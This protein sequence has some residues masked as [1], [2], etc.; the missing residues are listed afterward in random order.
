MPTADFSGKRETDLADG[1]NQSGTGAGWPGGREPI[2]NAPGIV[3]GLIAALIGIHL[4]S[5]LLGNDAYEWMML[6]FSFIPARYSPPADLTGYVFPGGQAADV[7]TFVTHI[8]LH[9]DWT[10]VIINCIWMLIF[11]SVVARRLGA[12][13]FLAFSAVTAAIGAASN[14]AA[15]WGSISVLVGASG[16]I[17]GQMAGA[18]RMM[19]AENGHLRNLNR[20]DVSDMHVLSLSETLTD[21]RAVTFI[22][23]WLGI[24]AVIGLAGI[25]ISGDINRIAWE[26][27]AGGF[28]GGLLLFG[29]F[30]QRSVR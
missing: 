2:V 23:L 5:T 13:R 30:D 14:L 28:A 22:L 25:G 20:P 3:I 10:H 12:V 7:W 17:S 4:I 21:R 26:A 6:T 19:F 11:G 9:G 15:Y 18:V 27:H 24:N 1:P 8:F 16:A 29:W